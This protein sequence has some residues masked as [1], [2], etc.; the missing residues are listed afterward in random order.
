MCVV[1]GIEVKSAIIWKAHVNKK[2]HLD[3]LKNLQEKQEKVNYYRLFII[4]DLVFNRILSFRIV[5]IICF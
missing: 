3:N 4:D 5:Y 1:C 2:S